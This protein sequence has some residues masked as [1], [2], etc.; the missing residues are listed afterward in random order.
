MPAYTLKIEVEG[1]THRRWVDTDDGVFLTFDLV[2][3]EWDAMR[4][5]GFIGNGEYLP[6]YKDDGGSECTLTPESFLDF[7]TTGVE[8][9][10]GRLLLVMK[11]VE[12]RPT[13]ACA[14]ATPSPAAPGLPR[15]AASSAYQTGPQPAASAS[16]AFM[17]PPPPPPY[18]YWGPQPHPTPG[19]PAMVAPP[20]PPPMP[21]ELT[22]EETVYGAPP[23][24]LYTYCHR[25][26]QLFCRMCASYVTEDHLRSRRHLVRLPSWRYWIWQAERQQAQPPM[27]GAW[28]YHCPAPPPPQP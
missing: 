21:A 15:P 9:N 18:P 5:A 17:P 19:D 26:Q 10:K 4:T 25:M 2:E 1:Q 3:K 14:A 27:A 24:V 28:Y 22:M 20:A 7:M 8:S 6:K 16:A 11:L 12:R 23:E 13:A